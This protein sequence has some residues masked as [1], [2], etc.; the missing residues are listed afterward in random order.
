MITSTVEMAT[1]GLRRQYQMFLRA[2]PGI[3]GP[4]A[5]FSKGMERRIAGDQRA[6]S[7]TCRRRC[8]VEGDLADDP[9]T[10]LAPGQR[11]RAR[12]QAEQH[13][14]RHHAPYHGPRR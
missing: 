3:V 12:G 14:R 6:D 8:L 13:D 7:V 9:V 5:G 10:F 1:S 2:L 11:L 4:D